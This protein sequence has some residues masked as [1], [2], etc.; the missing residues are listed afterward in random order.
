MVSFQKHSSE[1]KLSTAFCN[2]QGCGAALDVNVLAS[3]FTSPVHCSDANEGICH[4]MTFADLIIDPIQE[5]ED[6][7]KN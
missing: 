5:G 2:W 7:I 6:S 1:F 4:S 3:L